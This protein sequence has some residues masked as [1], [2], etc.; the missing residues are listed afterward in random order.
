MDRSFKSQLVSWAMEEG[1]TSK[2]INTL[3]A[4]Q[5]SLHKRYN[6]N[7]LLNKNNYYFAFPLKKINFHLQT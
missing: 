6:K 2:E 3:N 4:L 1:C 7:T 5:R